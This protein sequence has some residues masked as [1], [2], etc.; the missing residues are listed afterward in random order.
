MAAIGAFGPSGVVEWLAA[1][2][3][4]NTMYRTNV[5]AL[6][7]ALGPL[8]AGAAERNFSHIHTHCFGVGGIHRALSSDGRKDKTTRMPRM[9]PKLNMA[10]AR[11]LKGCYPAVARPAV[12]PITQHY[13]S[14][15]WR[16][17]VLDHQDGGR[18][19]APLVLIASQGEV[20]AQ[21]VHSAMHA[22]LCHTTV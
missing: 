3:R 7:G 17:E 8:A 6:H 16:R 22:T 14:L 19:A 2:Q 15:V 21:A 1:A 13:G 11:A 10:R 20:I 4:S 18:R 12:R 9:A 5:S